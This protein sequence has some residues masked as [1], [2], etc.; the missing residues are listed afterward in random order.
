ME[1]EYF[2][3][4]GTELEWY[5]F[6]KDFCMQWLRSLGLG[7]QNLR[8]RDHAKEELSHYSNATCDIEYRYPFGWGELW[9]VASR[10]DYDLKAH[11]AASGQDMQY[12]D[13]VTGERYVPYVVEP[14]LGVDRLLLTV[15]IDAYD[16]D[17]IGGEKR[18]VLRLH[19]RL[20]PVKAAILPLMKKPPLTALAREV[21]GRVMKTGRWF[22]EIDETGSIGK[23]YRRQDELGTPF[24]FTVDFESLDDKKVTIRDRDTTKQERIDIDAIDGVLARKVSGNG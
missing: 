11:Q 19:P 2:C 18:T 23:R 3:K 24:C 16:E 6:W 14:A 8:M 9:G 10:T 1:M 13:Q 21:F 12:L 20:A 4:P 7:G 17:E 5:A 22:L 15:L